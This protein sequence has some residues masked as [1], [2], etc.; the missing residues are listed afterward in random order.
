MP[1]PPTARFE[2]EAEVRA[3]ADRHFKDDFLIASDRDMVN[4][5]A[6]IPNRTG[7][8]YHRGRAPSRGAEDS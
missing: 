2:E 6:G 8:G 5:D 7:N 3:D 1:G 4:K